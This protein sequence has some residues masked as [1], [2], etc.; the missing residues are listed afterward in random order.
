MRVK[1]S[2]HLGKQPCTLCASV[3][4]FWAK[5]DLLVALA[6]P[7]HPLKILVPEGGLEPPRF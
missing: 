7:F 6:L 2:E 1:Q 5:R 4:D 3:C